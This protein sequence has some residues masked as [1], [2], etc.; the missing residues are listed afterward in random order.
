MNNVIIRDLR[1]GYSV[2]IGIVNT[3]LASL[4]IVACLVPNFWI[5]W[6]LAFIYTIDE[7]PASALLILA[8]WLW[9]VCSAGIFVS[10]ALRSF[11][12]KSWSL[13]Q[14]SLPFVVGAVLALFTYFAG[15]WP[16]IRRLI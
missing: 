12:K 8:I 7:H 13:F 4:L 15:W 5:T 10:V 2:A 6:F 11:I 9:G 1:V 14:Q 16:I 3:L